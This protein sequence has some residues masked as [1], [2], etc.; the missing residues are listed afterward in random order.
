MAVKELDASSLDRMLNEGME[1]PEVVEHEEVTPPTDAPALQKAKR[2]YKR[3]KMKK[4]SDSFKLHSFYCE[5]E[6]WKEMKWLAKRLS[7]DTRS[8][9]IR[10]LISRLSVRVRGRDHALETAEKNMAEEKNSP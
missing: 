8:A 1:K 10:M 3:R 9:L 5:P 7:V 2:T 4:S 6:M